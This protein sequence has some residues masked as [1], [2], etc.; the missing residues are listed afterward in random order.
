MALT[1]RYDG[2]RGELTAMYHYS[3]SHPV[4]NYATQSAP[5]VY[6]GDGSVKEFG[7]FKLGT[8]S[9]LPVDNDMVY[10]DMRTGQLKTTNLYDATQNIGSEFTLMNN[11]RWDRCIKWR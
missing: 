4:Y 5:F 9:F 8:T 7:D 11:Y 3:N 6:V 2:D 1:K 10:R